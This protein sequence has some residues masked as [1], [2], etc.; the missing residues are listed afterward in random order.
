MGYC[1]MLMDRK[2]VRETSPSC[3]TQRSLDSA[4]RPFYISE[5]ADGSKRRIITAIDPT[6]ICVSEHGPLHG[7]GVNLNNSTTHYLRKDSPTT[8]S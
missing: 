3:S 1:V 2:L 4:G 6:S 7:H 8:R 5:G